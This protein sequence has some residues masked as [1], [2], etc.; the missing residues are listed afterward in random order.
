MR[1]PATT[2]ATP[3]TI[4]IFDYSGT[5]SLEAPRFGRPEHLVRMLRETGLAAL[6]VETAEVYWND[7]VNPTWSEGSTT[8]KGYGK[9]M[10]ERIAKIG[11]A[12]N[13][14]PAQIAAAARRFVEGY[15]GHSRIDPHWR[16]L[17]E[18]LSGSPDAGM[19][20]ATDH[21]AEATEAITHF[22]EAWNIQ[23]ARCGA[24]G[25]AVPLSGG[26]ERVST[27]CLVANS[28]DLGVCKEDRRF[29]EI[30]KGRFFTGRV[31]RVV[32]IDDFGFNEAFEDG[33]AERSRIESRQ[34]KTRTVL[35]AV[36]EVEPMIIP[37]HLETAEP[38]GADVRTQIIAETAGLCE[39]ILQEVPQE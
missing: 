6:G 14:S 38:G 7:I 32:L 28:A 21:Y 23:A 27:S 30:L 33:Y 22:L 9:V 8:Q 11:L 15:L 16:P 3:E 34:I 1:H 18:N 17:L 25:G 26:R 5:L 39:K 31:R 37:F 4:V 19:V 35:E 36:F 20:I 29:W 24:T 12:P 2:T 10:A 13:A